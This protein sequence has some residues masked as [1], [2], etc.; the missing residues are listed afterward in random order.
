MRSVWVRVLVSVVVMLVGLGAAPRVAGSRGSVARVADATVTLTDIA[1]RVDLRACAQAR[2]RLGGALR[3]S[4]RTT[5]DPTLRG[6]SHHEGAATGAADGGPHSAPG[7][8]LSDPLTHPLHGGR[9]ATARQPPA[10]TAMGQK[11]DND[12]SWPLA[13]RSAS[14]QGLCCKRRRRHVSLPRYLTDTQLP[15]LRFRLTAVAVCA[16]T[17]QRRVPLGSGLTHR[18]CGFVSLRASDRPWL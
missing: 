5:V 12:H 16:F 3:D 8:R 4:S 10:S 18:P 7:W 14:T 11:L 15:I 2:H 6:L 1:A 13:S 9:A 17:R